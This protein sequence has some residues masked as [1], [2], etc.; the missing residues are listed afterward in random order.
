MSKLT[1]KFTE[2]LPLMKDLKCM[3]GRVLTLLKDEDADDAPPSII[4]KLF[5]CPRCAGPQ[6]VEPQECGLDDWHDVD[7]WP[8]ES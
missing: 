3:C 2:D 8:A 5:K 1:Y 6:W 4:A 7:D